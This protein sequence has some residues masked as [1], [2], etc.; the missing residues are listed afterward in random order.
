MLQKACRS[1][2]EVL[3]RYY[4]SLVIILEDIKCYRIL[5]FFD[6]S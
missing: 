5:Y 2:T 1:I 4:R 6:R 3:E